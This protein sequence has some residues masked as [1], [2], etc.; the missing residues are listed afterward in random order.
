MS[1]QYQMCD[2]KMDGIM[3]SSAMRSYW[4]ARAVWQWIITGRSS[5]LRGL[6]DASTAAAYTR[7][8]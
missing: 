6:S 8:S 1:P 7:S 5:C 4:S 2:E 3:P